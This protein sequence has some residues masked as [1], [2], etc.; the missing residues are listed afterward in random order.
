MLGLSRACPELWNTDRCTDIDAGQTTRRPL[1]TPT[2]S[3][4]IAITDMSFVECNGGLKINLSL[5][6]VVVH[7]VEIAAAPA[8]IIAVEVSQTEHAVSFLGW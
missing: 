4:T 3:S 7:Q 2:R 6:T 1:T 5:V 8:L